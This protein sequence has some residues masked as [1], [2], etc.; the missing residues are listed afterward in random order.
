MENVR[1]RFRPIIWVTSSEQFLKEARKPSYHGNCIK[2]SETL[3][4]LQHK[5]TDVTLNKPIQ[6][7]QA[8]LDISKVC[9]F[10]F[11][12]NVMQPHFG[13]DNL[14]ML[15]TDTD[16]LVYEISS[17]NPHYDMYKDLEN[18]KGHFD[19]S[20][21]PKGHTLF[22]VNNKKTAGKFKDD[23][24]TL[25]MEYIGIRAKMYSILLASS[26]EVTAGTD[27]ESLVHN[28][29]KGKSKKGFING[30]KT[31]AYM[32]N[33]E[34]ELVQDPM[35]VSAYESSTTKGIKKNI[36]TVELRHKHFKEC[37]LEDI[38]APEVYIPSLRS[39]NHRVFMFDQKKVTL[40]SLDDK[41]HALINGIHT[42][43]H[44]H[45]N[46]KSE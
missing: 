3:L 1:K 15:M 27:V 17:K 14:K 38:P 34:G 46:I 31:L 32:R 29:E 12:Y 43:A 40:N 19:F 25:I 26:E 28:Y 6:I 44:G 10:D 37:L 11:H 41:R 30:V 2:Y 4:A 35:E 20:D 23:K 33:K 9:M 45:C 5:V 21:Y 22:S 42:L 36:A 16:S 18:L 13:Q 7:G 24:G 8:V 39:V